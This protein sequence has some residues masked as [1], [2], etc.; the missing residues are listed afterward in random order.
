MGS[1]NETCAISNLPILEG[2]DAYLLL[3]VKS[4]DYEE[5]AGYHN[6]YSLW[7]PWSIPLLG[8]YDGYGRI[9]IPEGWHPTYL[10]S[11]LQ[12]EVLEIPQGR[13]PSHDQAV[14]KEDFAG[15]KGLHHLQDLVRDSRIKVYVDIDRKESRDMGM[16]FIRHD[17]YQTLVEAP[18]FR[19]DL[20]L[21]VEGAIQ[22]EHKRHADVKESPLHTG[23]LA[24]AFESLEGTAF[25]ALV[26]KTLDN[27]NRYRRIAEAS[28]SYGPPGYRGIGSYHLYISERLLAGASRKNPEVIAAIEEYATFRHVLI[29]FE[30]LRKLWHPQNGAGSQGTGWGSH[31]AL[32]H[33][34]YQSARDSF[35][36][37]TSEFEAIPRLVE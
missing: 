22:K 4:P 34:I 1:W 21:T 15:P 17:I 23:V 14:N 7:T 13:N 37:E 29:H 19:R 12:E 25:G 3:L 8:E 35:E 2:E 11:R 31:V 33:A 26:D 36:E 9:Q 24:D 27:L 10:L 30:F 16:C 32:A 6:G 18:I 5:K 20:I 28:G